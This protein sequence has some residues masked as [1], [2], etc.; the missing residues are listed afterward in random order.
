MKILLMTDSVV[1]HEISQ[2]LFDYHRDDLGLIVTT[3]ENN[4]FHTALAFDIP[5]L[6]FKSDDQVV[7]FLDEANITV[8]LGFLTWWPK[9]VKKPFLD[10]PNHGFINTHPSLL[11]YNKGKHYNFWALVE[12]APFG[13]TLHFVDGGIDSGDIVAQA[14]IPYDW[15]DNG[16]SLYRKAQVAMVSL[17]KEAYT[18]L[19]IL[20]ILPKKQD[21]LKGSFHKAYELEQ[22]SLIELDQYYKARDLLNLLR[23]RTFP[24][25]PACWF[26]DADAVYEIRIEIKRKQ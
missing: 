26:N 15:E 23:A 12:Q 25:Y 18:K 17:F 5:C 1:G 19:R 4:I 13:V 10:K 9:I 3:E 6:V 8:D 21:S 2:W 20:D 24:G 11:P 7:S 22:A 14:I 16:A